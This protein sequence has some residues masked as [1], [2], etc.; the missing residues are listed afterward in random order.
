MPYWWKLFAGHILT[1]KSKYP[2]TKSA[3][4]RNSE[5]KNG[6]LLSHMLAWHLLFRLTYFHESS[7][8][9]L[10]KG[11]LCFA[12]AYD[13]VCLISVVVCLFVCLF[14]DQVLIINWLIGRKKSISPVSPPPLF[15]FFFF[16]RSMPRLSPEGR[17]RA[18]RL[19][20]VQCFSKNDDEKVWTVLTGPWRTGWTLSTQN[21]DGG[22]IVRGLAD[23]E[24]YR[25]GVSRRA[26]RRLILTFA[27]QRILH[28]ECYL[29]LFHWN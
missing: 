23:S 11:V 17:G 2:P 7:W 28:R 21:L 9:H 6:W 3:S 29:A 5:Q 15:F 18:F 12:C 1:G 26:A 25:G 16:L 10:C 24:S 8:S 19:L 22:W 14:N 20:G 27:S 13:V 4:D